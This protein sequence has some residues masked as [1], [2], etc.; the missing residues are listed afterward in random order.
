MGDKQ[1]LF[2]LYSN[3]TG[4][5]NL[6]ARL[7]FNRSFSEFKSISDR[8]T[9][10]L[11]GEFA[12][13]EIYQIYLDFRQ[14]LGEK[15]A[16]KMISNPEIKD[17]AELNDKIKEIHGK[18]LSNA[19]QISHILK[20]SIAYG[21]FGIE[22][23]TDIYSV[24]A[25]NR[26]VVNIDFDIAKSQSKSD[27]ENIYANYSEQIYNLYIESDAFESA[28]ED[29]EE[30]KTSL[31]DKESE[32]YSVAR[33][34][35]ATQLTSLSAVYSLNEM[36]VD[37]ERVKKEIQIGLPKRIVSEERFGRSSRA[38][39]TK[40]RA[41][42]AEL[43][44]SWEESDLENYE[45]I[46][47]YE[48]YL[49]RMLRSGNIS[50]AQREEVQE[51]YNKFV[52]V[53][54]LPLSEVIQRQE[55]VKDI[56]ADI[57]LEYEILIRENLID[58]IH[59]VD[60]S[61][62]QT[63]KVQCIDDVKAEEIEFKGTMIENEAQL[64]TMLVHF[65]AKKD[66]SQKKKF[67]SEKVLLDLK[68]K[69]GLRST[70]EIAT[71]DP[72]YISAMRHY[73]DVVLENFVVRGFDPIYRQKNPKD[74]TLIEIQQNY[75]EHICTQT[76]SKS[77]VN[78]IR[79][80]TYGLLFDKN[81]IDPEGILISSIRNLESYAGIYDVAKRAS[82]HE[83]TSISMTSAPFDA[84]RAAERPHGNNE[85]DME[86]NLVKPSGICYFG[87]KPL[88]K[89]ERQEFLEVTKMAEKSGLPIVFVDLEAIER[90]QQ[91]KIEMTTKKD[92]EK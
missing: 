29:F 2:E 39:Y 19:K 10:I 22:Y 15:E 91:A 87:K 90:E 31:N 60:L 36:I 44:D 50:D 46:K 1:N 5:S 92:N 79:A 16:I 76:V 37:E 74:G 77:K 4:K 70:D 82:T 9:E 85:I 40:D 27:V 30:F 65:F 8:L 7:D 23:P 33:L 78:G 57:I 14:F 13:E 43:A 53:S 12:T 17:I 68:Q 42:Y 66:F 18:D 35:A 84:V 71:D 6:L 3:K 25:D 24:G 86:R 88:T 41:L 54:N 11:G 28:F 62:V 72:E 51:L 45:L 61:K 69:R 47:Q 58:N 64:G 49:L 48:N 83:A 80:G 55:Q 34:I 81:G 38:N 26:I 56:V 52:S 32:K 75:S 73:E 59:E 63:Q 21:K 89:E 20:E 67:Y